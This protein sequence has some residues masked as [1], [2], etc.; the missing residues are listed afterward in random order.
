MV[1]SLSCDG[2]IAIGGGSGTLN[3]MAV[4]YQANIPVVVLADTGGWAE[5][6]QG[7]Y[8]DARQ[9]YDYK[10]ATSA[11]EAIELLRKMIQ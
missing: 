3:E 11:Q 4:A 9:R 8:L 5:T 1:E 6:L 10:A 7:T 2:L